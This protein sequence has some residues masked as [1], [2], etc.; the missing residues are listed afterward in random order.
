MRIDTTE[1]H[2][3][4]DSRLPVRLIKTEVFEPANSN[5]KVDP[6]SDIDQ[7]DMIA[8]IR[9]EQGETVYYLGGGRYQVLDTGDTLTEV[10]F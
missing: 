7:V 6:Y 3:V 9:T 10:I 8:T 1:I 4:D 5:L 2:T